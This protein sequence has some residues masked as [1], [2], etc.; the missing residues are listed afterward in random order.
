[1]PFI[2][3]Q[4]KF[5]AA[6]KYWNDSWDYDQNFKV[7][8]DDVRVHGHNYVLDITITG[9]INEDSGFIFDIQEL[10]DIVNNKCHPVQNRLLVHMMYVV[11]V[12][13]FTQ[14]RALT[15]CCGNSGGIGVPESHESVS[16]FKPKSTR[17]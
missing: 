4:F 15:I 13:H 3:K 12:L 11:T 2:T 17:P 9:P 16:W 7:F 1:M 14:C 5:C 10:K 6:H 8:G